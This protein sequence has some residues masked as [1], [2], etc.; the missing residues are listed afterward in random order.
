M[1]STQI[2]LECLKLAHRDDR[3]PAQVIEVA[4]VYEEFVS[5]NQVKVKASG[6]VQTAQ[7]EPTATVISEV[8]VKPNIVG[9][10]QGKQSKHK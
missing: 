8:A 9:A 4:A 5:G 3:P 6:P 2:R 1:E 10:Y 7:P